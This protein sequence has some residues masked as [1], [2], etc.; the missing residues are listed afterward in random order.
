MSQVELFSKTDIIMRKKKKKSSILMC[1]AN[2]HTGLEYD[3]ENTKSDSNATAI[4]QKK[5][6]FAYEL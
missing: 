3:K 1:H 2:I 5:G 6:W 4:E